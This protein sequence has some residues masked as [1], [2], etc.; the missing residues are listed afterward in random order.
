VKGASE[1]FKR[2]G[3]RC[4]CRTVFKAKH[5][6]RC[7]FMRIRWNGDPSQTEHSV[8][9]IPCECGRSYGSEMG[10]L[11]V[12]LR[13]NRHIWKR[14]WLEEPKKGSSCLH[15]V[16]AMKPEFLISKAIVGIVRSKESGHMLTTPLSQPSLEISRIWIHLINKEVKRN[17]M[18]W[19]VM[20]GSA[21]I[22][23]HSIGSSMVKS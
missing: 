5:T 7:F 18:R 12:R 21:F 10:T 4:N 15:R 14:V 19:Q 23:A 2:I 22:P 16:T 3:N 11:T 6:L 1:K 13:E 8:Y 20:E 9:N 17:G